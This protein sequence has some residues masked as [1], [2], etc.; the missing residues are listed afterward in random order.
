[1]MDKVGG[2]D[3]PIWTAPSGDAIQE[4][5]PTR[6]QRLLV[7]ALLA[8]IG[9]GVLYPTA[10]ALLSRKDYGTFAFWNVPNRID[11]C[12]RR[13]YDGGL[14]QGIPALFES[15]DSAGVARWTFLSWTFS[16]RSI[17]A[18]VSPAR[19]PSSVC[20][21]ALY[22]PIGGGKWETYSLSGGP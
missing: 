13:Y 17:Y 10:A 8:F 21:M 12:G 4:G 11:Y 20:T 7:I 14:Q 16:G 18:N 5:R 19:P 3:D 6:R 15:R 1:M 9:L 22:I 2:I